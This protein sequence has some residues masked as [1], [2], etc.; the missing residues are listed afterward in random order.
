[1]PLVGCGCGGSIHRPASPPTLLAPFRL[2][3]GVDACRSSRPRSRPFSNTTLADRGAR[4]GR[5]RGPVL[6][7][8]DGPPSPRPKLFRRRRAGSDRRRF[9][10]RH[11]SSTASSPSEPSCRRRLPSSRCKREAIMPHRTRESL[12]EIIALTISLAE[13]GAR[14]DRP[15][16]GRGPNCTHR[17]AFDALVELVGARYGRPQACQ[18]SVL[19]Q[20]GVPGA[21]TSPALSHDRRRSFACSQRR[22]PGRL[23]HLRTSQ[24][25]DERRP[26]TARRQPPWSVFLV[27]EQHP[28]RRGRDGRRA[29][30]DGR[31][32]ARRTRRSGARHDLRA[33]A[34]ARRCAHLTPAAASASSSPSPPCA[35]PCPTA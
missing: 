23:Q 31:R 27:R 15:D 25:F 17:A 1:M 6:T 13:S 28:A 33:A 4:R 20:G 30:A 26:G 10:R 3:T 9:R 34:V 24:G 5:G 16:H 19:R 14:L 12:D 2:T 32:H 21:S 11:P 7:A 29:R 8:P 22:T 18:S 35:S